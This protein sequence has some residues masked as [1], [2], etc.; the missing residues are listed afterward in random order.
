MGTDYAITRLQLPI[1]NI[2]YSEC[3]LSLNIYEIINSGFSSILNKPI[4]IIL[5]KEGERTI[6]IV[7]DEKIILR[8]K[9]RYYMGVA[10]VNVKSNGSI[11][12]PAYI[13]SGY[14]RN[15]VLA[16]RKKFPATLGLNVLG[17]KVIR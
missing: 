3:T 13:K 16:E 7:P 12:F 17:V 10:V 2:A 4:Y 6:D 1:E 8:K 14:I 9:Y 15:F 11:E 5:Q